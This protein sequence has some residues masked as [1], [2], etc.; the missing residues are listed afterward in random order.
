[1]FSECK[2]SNLRTFEICK[3]ASFRLV[4]QSHFRITLFDCT[5]ESHLLIALSN[6]T[7]KL[8]FLITVFDH[9]ISIT[10]FDH[11][12][13]QTNPLGLQACFTLFH[14][15]K[16][17]RGIS[18]PGKTTQTLSVHRK[19]TVHVYIECLIVISQGDMIKR[20]GLQKGVKFGVPV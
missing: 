10:F 12:S 19:G 2:L 18:V 16:L 7:S 17:P 15:K 8:H 6:H 11:A 5:C 9:T 4:T 13:C 3:L 20:S 1:M 14:T